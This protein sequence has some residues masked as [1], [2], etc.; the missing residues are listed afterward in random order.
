M[1]HRKQPSL[2]SLE[3]GR[4]ICLYAATW[5]SLHFGIG[6]GGRYARYEMS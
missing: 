3:R 2:Q 1:I 6:G 4:V 5:G